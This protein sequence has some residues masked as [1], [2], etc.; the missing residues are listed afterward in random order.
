M[1]ASFAAGA[2]LVEPVGNA[3]ALLESVVEGAPAASAAGAA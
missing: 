1:A 3:V 2:K